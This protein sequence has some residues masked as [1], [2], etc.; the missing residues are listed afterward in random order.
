M[1]RD[2]PSLLGWHGFTPRFDFTP[3]IYVKCWFDSAEMNKDDKH[4]VVSEPRFDAKCVCVRVFFI[5]CVCVCV[6]GALS[7]FCGAESCAPTSLLFHYRSDAGDHKEA[8]L[9]HDRAGSISNGS[10]ISFKFLHW[11]WDFISDERPQNEAGFSH[12]FQSPALTRISGPIY[13]RCILKF[14]IRGAVMEYKWAVGG[15]ARLLW[16][17]IQG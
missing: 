17:N 10:M 4:T 1:P 7:T 14:H 9:T 15:F 2:G 3:L 13:M 11:K 8:K 5:G 16:S 12:S 6:P